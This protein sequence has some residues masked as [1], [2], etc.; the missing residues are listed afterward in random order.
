MTTHLDL[1]L[2]QEYDSDFEGGEADLL[3][4]REAERWEPDTGDGQA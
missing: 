3:A 2:L 1:L 4:L